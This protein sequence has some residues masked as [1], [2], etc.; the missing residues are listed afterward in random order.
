MKDQAKTLLTERLAQLHCER[1][2]V[3]LHERLLLTAQLQAALVADKA[4]QQLKRRIAR[5]ITTKSV[6]AAFL[7]GPQASQTGEGFQGEGNA[8]PLGPT[9]FKAQPRG[10]PQNP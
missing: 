4:E 8:S 9:G 6:A 2:P 3:W 5:V 10:V 1:V 7:A